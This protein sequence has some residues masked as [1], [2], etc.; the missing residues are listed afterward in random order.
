M[1]QVLDFTVPAWVI[2]VMTMALKTVDDV[3]FEPEVTQSMASALDDVCR[4]LNVNGNL[5]ERE[6]LATRI[7]DLVRG[8]ECDR[9]GSCRKPTKLLTVLG[10]RFETAIALRFWRRRKSALQAAGCG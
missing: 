3:V 4:A 2:G 9:D 7:I 1:E 10:A 6:I 8:G 5:R